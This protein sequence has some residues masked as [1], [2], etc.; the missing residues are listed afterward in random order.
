MDELDLPDL[1]GFVR[2]R[3]TRATASAPSGSSRQQLATAVH[4]S[5]GYIAKIE[6][7]GAVSPSTGVLDA[8]STA[9]GLDVDEH[10]HLY[11]LAGHTEP[12]RDDD[13]LRESVLGQTLDA[14]AP[15][16]AVVLTDR[17]DIVV[18]NR[19]FEAAFPGVRECGNTL[20]WIFTDPHARLVLEE[21]EREAGL[22]V[23]ALRH[24]AARPRDRRHVRELVDELA[25]HPDFRRLWS[26]GRV[27]TH[28]TDPVV[29]L[30]NPRSGAVYAVLTQQF[31]T[32]GNGRPAR[33]VVG[34]LTDRAGAQ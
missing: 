30:R 7:G 22:A 26:S 5:V 3:R 31:R 1:G 4:S 20:R 16:P 18:G 8:L 29:R 28:R 13:P 11:R 17:F 19:A 2:G 32:A 15:N 27:V 33:M 10:A 34:L 14:L 12:A 25:E 9:L 21:W 24:Y 23:G 6:Q